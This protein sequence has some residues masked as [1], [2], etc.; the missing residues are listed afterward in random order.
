MTTPPLENRIAPAPAGKRKPPRRVLQV[1]LAMI[2]AQGAKASRKP[3]KGTDST[4]VIFRRL[5]D[6]FPAFKAY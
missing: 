5:R 2:R 4:R 6:S 3:R 1:Y